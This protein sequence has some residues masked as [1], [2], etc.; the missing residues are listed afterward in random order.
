MPVPAITIALRISRRVTAF[1]CVGAGAADCARGA[2]M[3][4]V[5]SATARAAARTT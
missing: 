5:Q 4:A 1:A 2:T 3:A